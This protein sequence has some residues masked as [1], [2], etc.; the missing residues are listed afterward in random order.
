[1]IKDENFEIESK[2]IQKCKLSISD[3]T[4]LNGFSEYYEDVSKFK[5]LDALIDEE[6]KLKDF[7]KAKKES[8][9][10]ELSYGNDLEA[11]EN[12]KLEQNLVKQDYLYDDLESKSRRRS[13]Q[14]RFST[15][16]IY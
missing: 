2:Y 15:F 11:E 13:R 5:L 1:M 9:P 10:F 14:R 6:L 16:I 4:N 12:R 8:E 3:P 7:K